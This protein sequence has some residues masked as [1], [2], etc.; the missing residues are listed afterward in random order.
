M[1]EFSPSPASFACG[2][3]QF[4][5]F[6]LFCNSYLGQIDSTML[7]STFLWAIHGYNLHIGSDTIAFTYPGI[8]LTIKCYI[9]QNFL[10]F[11]PAK[12]E[13]ILSVY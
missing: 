4:L 8:D 10:H 11:F 2:E 6:L 9:L 13:A 7:F 3:P 5:V 1:G 12:S